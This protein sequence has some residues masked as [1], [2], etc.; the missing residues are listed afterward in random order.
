M[1]FKDVE[2]IISSPNYNI[3]IEWRDLQEQ[4]QRFTGRNY[5]LA[6]LD[7]DPDFQRGYVWTL[8]Q[9]I[10]YV[11]FMLKGGS[12]GVN[13]ILFNCIGWQHDY[14]GPFVIV[15]GKQRL[16]AALEFL[17]NKFPVFDTYYKD[18]ED[19]IPSDTNFIFSINNLNTRKEVLA[20]YIQMNSGGT[21]HTESELNRVRDLLKEID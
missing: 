10:K 1:K 5:G 18:F 6:A 9:K 4:I 13:R 17:D 12:F 3:N 16:N 20:W 7:L 2:K 14:E 15:D 21:V 8:E 11:E 19:T